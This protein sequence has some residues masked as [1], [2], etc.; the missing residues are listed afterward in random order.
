MAQLE[1]PV[2]QANATPENGLSR[3]GQYTLTVVLIAAAFAA[4]SWF[5][6]HQGQQ[7]AADAGLATA[8]PAAQPDTAAS[9]ATIPP[10]ATEQQPATDNS[11]TTA[12]ADTAAQ[13][14]SIAQASSA[15]GNRAPQTQHAKAKPANRFVAKMPRSAASLASAGKYNR[16]PTLITH[17]RPSYP[18][19]AL[20]A[21]EEGTVLVL[22]QVDVNG[23]V[24]DAR[25][26]VRSGSS[27]LD[28]AAVNEVRRWQFEPALHN[29]KPIVASVEV[30]VRYRLAD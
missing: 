9:P 3:G 13:P 11:A 7:D 27:V 29:G 26:D 15:E 14:A 10:P 25:V 12:S 5:F 30:P 1:Q 8:L 22:A 28:R 17:P 24:D 6:Y 16:Q 4:S 20:R 2:T 23:R 21:G 18:V 19:Q